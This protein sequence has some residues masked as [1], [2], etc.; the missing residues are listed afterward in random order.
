MKNAKFIKSGKIIKGKGAEVFVKIGI[1]T[2]VEDVVVDVPT[3]ETIEELPVVEMKA[4]EEILKVSKP[5]K[6]GRKPK[7]R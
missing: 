3:D 2:Y 6:R 1:A 4:K 5:K 7:K